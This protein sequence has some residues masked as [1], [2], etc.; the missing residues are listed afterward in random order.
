MQGSKVKYFNKSFYQHHEDKSKEL[1]GNLVLEPKEKTILEKKRRNPRM[2]FSLRYLT[3][4]KKNISKDV[5]EQNFSAREK[6]SNAP[7]LSMFFT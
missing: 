1:K 7:Y 6:G 2:N 3:E 5:A 4:Q